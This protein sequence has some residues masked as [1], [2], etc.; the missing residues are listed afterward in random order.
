MSRKYWLLVLFVIPALILSA[1]GGAKP[2]TPV[3]L[4]IGYA[5]S[6]DTLNPTAGLLSEAWTMYELVYSSLY[7]P[8][9]D[10]SFKLDLATS[11]T[12]AADNMS[13]TIKIKP[14]VK[15]H[16]GTPLTAKDV[17]FSLNFYR[18]NTRFPVYERVH[19]IFCQCDCS[20]RYNGHPHHEF[21]GTQH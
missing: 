17:A 11:V 6:P 19:H 12:P 1:C 20:R 5:G 9:Y 13:Y 15:F 4:R 3:I 7:E 14:N 10:N 2:K 18:E 16:D 21:S 8:Q